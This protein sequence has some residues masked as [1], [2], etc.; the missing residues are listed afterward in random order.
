[1]V[2][3]FHASESI[4]LSLYSSQQPQGILQTSSVYVGCGLSWLTGEFARSLVLFQ[5]G[6]YSLPVSLFVVLAV[7]FDG[8]GLQ[9]VLV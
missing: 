5:E 1:L 8:F 9:F 7:L 3:A 6:L 2:A 4:K